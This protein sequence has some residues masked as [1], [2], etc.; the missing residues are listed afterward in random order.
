MA[1]SEAETSAAPVLL[2]ENDILEAG[3]VGRKPVELE[4]GDLLFRQR[5]RVIVKAQLVGRRFVYI[6]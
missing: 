1:I 2:K 5:F 6:D 3:I 4:K